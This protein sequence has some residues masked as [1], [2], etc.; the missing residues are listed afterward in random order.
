MTRAHGVPGAARGATGATDC[1]V[2]GCHS[3]RRCEHGSLTA[4]VVVVAVALFALLG[5]VVDGGRAVAA[6]AAA[7]NDASQAARAGAGQLSESALRNGSIS[8]DAPLAVRAAEAYV[9]QT[10]LSGS[11][12]VSVSGQTVTVH[13]RVDDP[14][15]IL[16]IIGINALPVSAS[17]SATDVH[18]VTRAD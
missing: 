18:G 10:G 1:H 12:S 11:S 14:T 15:V 8:I 17:A 2:L 5:L 6:H 3:G 16:G 9:A 4:F 7:L 13:I